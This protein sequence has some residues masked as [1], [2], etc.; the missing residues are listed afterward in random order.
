MPHQDEAVALGVS[1]LINPF[2][3]Q[4]SLSSVRFRLSEG[5]S[6]TKFQ[7]RECYPKHI[8]L[9]GCR[10]REVSFY[11]T[12]TKLLSVVYAFPGKSGRTS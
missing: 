3:N 9:D 7:I 1:A 12:F 11:G 6:L 8:S 4:S 10:C 5:T 2:D